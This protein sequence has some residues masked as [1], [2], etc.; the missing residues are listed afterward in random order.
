MAVSWSALSALQA[1]DDHTNTKK[2]KEV[3]ALSAA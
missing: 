3:P 2:N 1:R